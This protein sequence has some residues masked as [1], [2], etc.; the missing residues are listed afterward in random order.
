MYIYIYI[1]VYAYVYIYIYIYIYI[2]ILII[3]IT[4]NIHIYIYICVVDGLEG[5]T[6]A[7]EASPQRLNKMWFT[8]RLALSNQCITTNIEF[9]Q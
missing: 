4:I 1:Y 9:N 3:I 7:G 5:G 8:I 2:L 6:T